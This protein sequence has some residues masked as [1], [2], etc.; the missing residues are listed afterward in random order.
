[1]QSR[2]FLRLIVTLSSLT[3]GA[4]ACTVGDDQEKSL[5]ADAAAQIDREVP[6]VTDPGVNDYITRLG[7][8]LARSGD[9]QDREWRFRV[10]DAEQ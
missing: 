7:A 6:F 8:T 3:V 1:M 9:D 5:G 10:I 4:S 2:S